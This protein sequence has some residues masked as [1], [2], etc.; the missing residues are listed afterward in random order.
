MRSVLGGLGTFISIHSL[1]RSPDADSVELAGTS[2]AHDESVT[3]TTVCE[4]VEAAMAACSIGWDG[5]LMQR[6]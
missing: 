5:G 3:E 4:T 1:A 6:H 2:T